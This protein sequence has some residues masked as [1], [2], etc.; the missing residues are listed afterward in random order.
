M[1]FSTY[2]PCTGNGSFC[3]VRILAQGV[4][5]PDT[6]RTFLQFLSNPR[7]HVHELPPVP[8]VVF[9]SPGGSVAGALD[10]GRIIRNKKMDTEV[11]T[12][13][14]RVKKG[15]F[16]EE[17]FVSS[18]VCASACSLAFA[19]GVTRSLDPSARI[20]VHQFSAPSGSI[21]DSAT[22]VTLTVLANYF[23]LMGVNRSLL[24]RASLVP[25]TSMYWLTK[26]EATRFRLD[27][28]QIDLT[29]W[30]ISATPQGSPILKVMQSISEGREVLVALVIHQGSVAVGVTTI[31]S[32]SSYRADRIAQ[33][34]SG[35]P[36][37][38]S[39]CGERGCFRTTPVQA[40][41]K[42]ENDTEIRF[43]AVSLLP[44]SSLRALASSKTLSIDDGFGRPT[45]DVSLATDLSVTGFG[46]GAALLLR[47]N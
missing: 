21:G 33:F 24:D 41:T 47:Q 46:N 36:A 45:S 28:T 2:W 10:L 9:D 11:A 35:Q 34:P 43:Q 12:T 38:I 32:K 17:V 3:G 13:Y 23:D 6:G 8:T 14:S 15:T 20:G 16:D 19:G 37:Q 29:P 39:L 44:S 26:S 4:I 18:A 40:W 25:P 22:Q 5:Q 1:R 7:S 42:N 27:N 30:T 31:L